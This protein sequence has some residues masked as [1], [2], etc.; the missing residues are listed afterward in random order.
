MDVSKMLSLPKEVD[1]KVVEGNKKGLEQVQKSIEDL[2]GD[3][4]LTILRETMTSTDGSS[5]SQ[6]N[7]HERQFFDII[8]SDLKKLLR[9]L[10]NYFIP[11]LE[12][13]GYEVPKNGEISC[14]QQYNDSQAHELDKIAV[15]NSTADPVYILDK[16][17]V[18]IRPENANTGNMM[19]PLQKNGQ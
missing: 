9:Y 15:G 16:Y 7:V 14:D 6:A 17:G 13:A 11:H 8:R 3:V 10:N 18:K 1:L 12:F 5:Y 4:Y 19:G 2:K